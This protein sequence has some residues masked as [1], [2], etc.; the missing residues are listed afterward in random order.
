VTLNFKLEE[1][2][3]EETKERHLNLIEDL[4]GEIDNCDSPHNPNWQP[5]KQSAGV[6]H[7]KDRSLTVS[8]VEK[9]RLRQS[10]STQEN[11]ATYFIAQNPLAAF[12][13]SLVS[14]FP[15]ILDVGRGTR[16]GQDKMF[17]LTKDQLADLEIEKNFVAGIE[18]QPRFRTNFICR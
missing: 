11:W 8:I 6:F 10:L 1:L 15:E 14:P 5:D 16:T 12:E 2:L 7:K 9:E 17:I 3:E 4:Y 13:K 18:N